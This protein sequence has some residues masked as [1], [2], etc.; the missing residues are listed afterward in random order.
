MPSGN[1]KQRD[2]L[3]VDGIVWILL[4]ACVLRIAAV[5]LRFENLQVDRDAYLAIAQNLLDGNG[6]CSTINQP[7]A[8]RPPLYPLFV[9]V[10]KGGGGF[11][12]LGIGQVILGTATVWLTWVLA[13]RCG[14]SR[15]AGLIAALLVAVD[16]LLIEYTTQAMTETLSTLLLTA[17]LVATLRDGSELTKSATVGALFGLASLCRPSIW[18]F[19]ALAGLCWAI[20]NFRRVSPQAPTDSGSNVE[21]LK[22]A[23]ICLAAVTLTVSPWVIRNTLQFGRPIL[24]TTHGGYT[25][26][27][28][29]NET[30]YD[31]V[32]ASEKGATWTANSLQNWQE[33]N[34]QRLEG[35]GIAAADEVAQDAALSQ[36]AKEWI[37]E[38]PLKFAQSCVFRC[39]RFWACR[40]SGTA[41]IPTWLVQMIGACYLAIFILAIIGTVRCGGKLAALWPLPALVLAMT[42]VHTV[43]WSNARMRAGIVPVIA[44]SAAAVFNSPSRRE[45]VNATNFQGELVCLLFW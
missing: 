26:L 11:A 44:L 36:M 13:I 16:P 34:K 33:T 18:A 30:F 10:C 41:G 39:K 19:G 9:A 28:A 3:R 14:F 27:L 7:T 40:P 38:N 2:L 17:L 15:I 4:L 29:N 21:R 32:V 5:I 12:L 35:I 42:L 22:I 24:M 37:A 43:Y 23:A 25:L 20:K 45:S 31:E 6:F 8:F 1:D